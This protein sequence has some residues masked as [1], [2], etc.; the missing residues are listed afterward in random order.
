M[1][2][3]SKDQVVEECSLV[4]VEAE[5]APKRRVGVKGR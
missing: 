5:E 1:W 2:A 4:L 3:W